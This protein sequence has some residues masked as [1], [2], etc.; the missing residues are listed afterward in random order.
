MGRDAVRAKLNELGIPFLLSSECDHCP[1]KDD[2]RW[3]ASS[4]ETIERVATLED[5]YGGDFFFTDK[6]IPLRLA[7]EEMR[8]NP[9]PHD[10]V[11]GCK[12]GLCGI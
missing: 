1:H 3:L 10:S 12:N 8:K 2:S 11:F 7:V 9:K 6:R 4:A 5:K